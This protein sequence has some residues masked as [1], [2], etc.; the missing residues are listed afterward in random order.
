MARITLVRPVTPALCTAR[1]IAAL[2]VLAA[3]RGD[4]QIFINQGPARVVCMGHW[5]PQTVP[6]QLLSTLLLVAGQSSE[7]KNPPVLTPLLHVKGP[8]GSSR[9]D[10]RHRPR[11]QG[12]A[13][14]CPH[15]TQLLLQLDQAP[16][17]RCFLREHFC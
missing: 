8:Q 5:P 16:R 3:A 9:R 15:A 14:A 4:T 11:L 12:W 6:V 17:A 2:F 1:A 7:S 10:A 13:V